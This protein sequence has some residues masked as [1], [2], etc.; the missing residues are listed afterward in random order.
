VERH[1]DRQDFDVYATVTVQVH[2]PSY[3][4]LLEIAQ[5]GNASTQLS[6]AELDELEF[7]SE[8][9]GGVSIYS[10]LDFP[11]PSGARLR[12]AEAYKMGGTGV[13]T[14]ASLTLPV[15]TDFGRTMHIG[16]RTDVPGALYDI[17]VEY[18]VME[19]EEITTPVAHDHA[20]CPS[21]SVL[22]SHAGRGV[23]IQVECNG[24]GTCVDGKC[25]CKTGFYGKDCST[26]PFSQNE[27]AASIQFVQP[28]QGTVWTSVPVNLA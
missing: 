8:V 12:D 3:E 21:V 19:E 14:E 28:G 16:V 27:K 5:G 23:T 6:R 24:H 17:K 7:E 22:I 26:V 11:Y 10:A 20:V 4:W 15:W 2:P 25:I 9:A 18:S 13:A 1:D